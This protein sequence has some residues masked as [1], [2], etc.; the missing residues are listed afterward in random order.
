MTLSKGTDKTCEI[1]YNNP[2]C[3]DAVL[4]TDHTE[5]SSFNILNRLDYLRL[6][7]VDPTSASSQQNFA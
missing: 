7:F 6:L 3:G 4:N 1:Y 5:V 2:I